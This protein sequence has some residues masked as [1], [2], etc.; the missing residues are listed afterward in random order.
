[1]EK[2]Y[3]DRSLYSVEYIREIVLKSKNITE[4]CRNIGI[5]DRGG[6]HSFIKNK[7]KLYNIDTSHFLSKKDLKQTRSDTK[8]INVILIQN[9]TYSSSHSLKKR[10]Y[11]EGLKRPICEQCGQGEEWQGKTLSL[12]LDHINGIHNDNRIENLKILCPNCHAITDT[13]CGKNRIR[14]IKQ[15]KNIKEN[16]NKYFINKIKI[17][18]DNSPQN[19]P[20]WKLI[21]EEY[22][23]SENYSRICAKKYNKL[24]N[25][26]ID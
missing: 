2:T 13:Y 14:K 23:Y 11:K 18:I 12:H 8:D 7:I 17:L 22:K 16:N 26:S 15:S 19:F 1:M 10:L 25:G 3:N 20:L 4:V 9:S 6:S 24:I 5:M 21:K